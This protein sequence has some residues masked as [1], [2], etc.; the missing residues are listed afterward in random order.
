M[1]DKET[2]ECENPWGGELEEWITRQIDYLL[3]F[4]K[5]SNLPVQWN[6]ELRI[7]EGRCE[8]IYNF[9]TGQSLISTQ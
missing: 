7:E 9:K 8:G 3:N 4:S 5:N 2:W 1:V 6:I